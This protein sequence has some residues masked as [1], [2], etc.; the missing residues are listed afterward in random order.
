MDDNVPTTYGGTHINSVYCSHRTESK[1]YE[2]ILI[3][4]KPI[5]SVVTAQLSSAIL[6]IS[7]GSCE[8]VRQASKVLQQTLYNSEETRKVKSC[9]PLPLIENN[10]IINHIT[11]KPHLVNHQQGPQYVEYGLLGRNTIN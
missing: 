11:S 6:N 5:I 2:S 1:I 7:D 8:N 10:I 4:H 9:T 3:Y